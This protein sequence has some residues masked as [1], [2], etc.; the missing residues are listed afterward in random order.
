MAPTQRDSKSAKSSRDTRSSV[1]GGQDAGG[2]HDVGSQGGESLDIL[3]MAE[4]MIQSVSTPFA[5]YLQAPS[6]F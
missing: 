2:E 6:N 1:N 5:V 4:K 3:E